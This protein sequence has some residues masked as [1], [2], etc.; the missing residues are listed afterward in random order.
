MMEQIIAGGVFLLVM[1]LIVTEKVHRTA[2]AVLG[3]AV[4]LFTKVI[5]LDKAIEHID[6]NTLGVLLGMMIFVGVVRKSGLFEYVAIKAAKLAKGDPWRIMMAFIV[7]TAF[8]SAM[9]DNVTTVLLIAPMT[10]TITNILNVD[11]VPYLI[12]QA[13]ASNIGGTGTLIG[14]PPNI[15]I[16]S[17]TGFDFMEF[18]VNGFGKLGT[19]AFFN[20][21]ACSNMS[22]GALIILVAVIVLM[23]F[24]YGRKLHVDDTAKR[25]IMRLEEKKAIKDAGLMKKS[26]V[27]IVLVA[28]GFVLHGQIGIE[29]SVIALSAAAVMFVIGRQDVEDIV[30]DVEWPT[31]IFFM[32]LFVIVGAMVET[33]I[34]EK[35]ADLMLSSTEGHPVVTMLVLLWASALISSVLDNIPFVATLI[36]MVALME[37]GGMDVFPLWWA[38]SL[39]ACLGGNGTL[40]G[41]SANVVVA[42]ISGKN[43]HP[44]SFAQFTKVGFPVMIFTMLIATAYML[45][46]FA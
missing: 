8:F 5:S 33:G 30:Y 27:M 36:P 40:I 25:H 31:I 26:L 18:L 42:S 24:I 29:S 22:L 1:V 6:F 28:A 32:G 23:K 19:S 10:L 45:I 34:I 11:P 21:T 12:T 13:L 3:M 9:L 46:K 15:M 20:G 2:A 14:D 7:I 38:I 35:L 16:G 44:I 39:G 37:Q 41:A 4:L 17:A 43:G